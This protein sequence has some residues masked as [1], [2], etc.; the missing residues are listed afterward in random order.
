MNEYR[1]ME[2]LIE[3]HRMGAKEVVDEYFRFIVK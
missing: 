3:G 1:N 2:K